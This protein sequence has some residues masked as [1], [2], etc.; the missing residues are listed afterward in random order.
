MVCRRNSNAGSLRESCFVNMPSFT[1]SLRITLC[2][3]ACGMCL[4]EEELDV[5]SVGYVRTLCL[6]V[7]KT[8]TV[9]SEF[10]LLAEVEIAERRGCMLLPCIPHPGGVGTVVR[11]LELLM[12]GRSCSPC[13]TRQAWRLGWW[14]LAGSTGLCGTDEPLGCRRSCRLAVWDN[15]QS[16]VLPCSFRPLLLTL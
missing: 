13:N 6:E 16:V 4:E 15:L 2:N 1:E 9:A 7:V 10:M 5:Y 3:P 14:L 8:G 11:Y 12:E